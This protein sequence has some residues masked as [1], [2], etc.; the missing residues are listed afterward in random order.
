[1]TIPGGRAELAVQPLGRA[2]RSGR[3]HRGL[4]G[5]AAVRPR[6]QRYDPGAPQGPGAGPAGGSPGRRR[7]GGDLVR[8]PGPA[9]QPARGG[10]EAGR[11]AD[12]GDGTG[13]TD[14]ARHQAVAGCRRSAGSTRRNSAADS[15]R[16]AGQP[17]TEP[18]TTTP[19]QGTKSRARQRPPK[20]RR[21][22]LNS[23]RPR[24]EEPGSTAPAQ[25]TKSRAQQRPP[26][27]RRAGLKRL[28]GR[29]YPARVPET[30]AFV[31]RPDLDEATSIPLRHFIVCGDSPLAYRLIGELRYEVR[32]ARDRDRA[33]AGS[34][35][36]ERI[37][38]MPWVDLVVSDRLDN[39]AF[40]AARIESGRRARP[41]RPGR[42]GNVDAALL[43]QEINPDLRI[44]IRMFNYSLGERIS[45]LLNNCVVL[46]AAAIAAPAFVAAALDDAA[47]APIAVA[48]RTVVGIRRERTRPADVICRARRHGSARY[49]ARGAARRADERADLVLAEVEADRRRPGHA[50]APATSALL[51]LIFGPPAARGPRRASWSSSSVGTARARLGRRASAWAR[52]GVRRAHH[53][54]DRQ[55]RPGRRP[56]GQGRPHRC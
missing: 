17:R 37:A 10:H 51:P 21:A 41:G 13:P 14:P 55:R 5:G 54:A 9:G 19:A 1:M 35:W 16:V 49:R 23:A 4:Q 45:A 7:A 38:E 15:S 20:A 24:H 30:P 46:S 36:V 29:R 2:G 26:K 56:V 53:R 47:T 33:A 34:V 25:G 43:A 52:R 12:R 39:A 48:D 3:E 32:R 40:S 42:R 27:A 22:G 6:R 31:V 28:I 44:V 11:T 8:A 18:R 50:A